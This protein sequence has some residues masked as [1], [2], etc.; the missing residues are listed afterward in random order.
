MFAY[1][2]IFL[3]IK[4]DILINVKV[5][6]ALIEILREKKTAISYLF[7]TYIVRITQ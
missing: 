6:K 1:I 2:K 3:C 4:D 7:I 5:K